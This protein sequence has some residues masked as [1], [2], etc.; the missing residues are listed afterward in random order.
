MDKIMQNMKTIGLNISMP[1]DRSLILI[2]RAVTF[3]VLVMIIAGV[4]MTAAS[5]IATGT[6]LMSYFNLFPLIAVVFNFIGLLILKQ[7][8][9]HTVGWLFMFIG[10]M[11]G[12]N[13]LVGGYSDFDQYV[14][15]GNPDT[16]LNFAILL[17]HMVWWPVVILPIT[18]VLLYFP[19]GK[20]QSPRWRIVAFAAILGMICGMFTAFHSD[21]ILV[22]DIGNPDLPD[23]KTSDH[24]LEG[25]AIVSVAL[26][27]IGI[28]GSL[29][30]VFIRFRRSIA[31]ERLQMKWLVYSALVTISL[32]F[33][34]F[35]ITLLL[36][37]SP[38]IEQINNFIST[39][40]VL[41]IPVAC[42]VAI[43]RH[44]L[45]DID[46]IISRTLIYGS[47]TTLIVAIYLVIVGGSG[48]VFQT[49]NNA[50]GGLAAAGVI[51]V[52]FQPLRERLQRRVT[53]MLYGERDDP[54]AVLTRLAHHSETAE[55]PTTVLPNLVQTIA[56]MLKI[57]YVAIRLPDGVGHM[58]V[59]AFWG[60][61]SDDMQTMALT[62]QK[63]IIGDLIVAQRGPKD[64][65]NRHEQD[66]LGT[67][68]ALTATTVR[69]VQLSDELRR[70]R[71]RI[72][73]AREEERRRL[74]RDLHDGLGPLLASQVLGLEAVAQFMPT[75]IEKA[76]SLL[77]S[78]KTQAHEAILD[79]RRLVYDLRPPALDD[80]GLIGALRQ[81]ASR[82]ET[83]V[84]RFSFDVPTSLP[85]LPAAVETA[86]YRIA[87]EAMTNVVHHAQA[88]RCTVRLICTDADVLVEVRDN[89]RGL[90][91]NYQTGVGLQAMKERATELNGE[92]FVDLLPD[93]GTRVQ[94]K[95]PLEVYVE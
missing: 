50:L 35:I 8:P 75:D 36:P 2:A 72:V 93:G 19:D 80:L 22:M 39:G 57:P 14:L 46:I 28:L 32:S 20:L 92:F 51:A 53:R 6:S 67:I 29:T 31:T 69:G 63:E 30:S 37:F 91:Q 7:H 68:A 40:L 4:G 1:E 55:T 34:P 42:G 18:L 26:L 33:L 65:F 84:L 88:M 81:S 16:A 71:Q 17:G 44:R 85:E 61:A 13:I 83:G 77:G 66:L 62:F 76:Q 79:V 43:I 3:L 90:S 45:W 54:V 73:T 70:S 27:I 47:L 21:P 59:I 48:I 56:H 23:L 78:L 12:L 82:F 5:I 60:E 49:Q 87:Q 24:F 41:I 94:A 64:E 89:G 25:L 15:I 11:A 52:L 95:L 10:F 38:A 9:K 74:R 86:I 58:E